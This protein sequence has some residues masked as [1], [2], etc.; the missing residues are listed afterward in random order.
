MPADTLCLEGLDPAPS[1]GLSVIRDPEL[2]HHYSS[3]V[4]M[5][6]GKPGLANVPACI[7]SVAAQAE[8]GTDNQTPLRAVYI[9]T[10]P[11][12]PVQPHIQPPAAARELSTLHLALPPLYSK[13]TLPF[14][15][16]QLT[17]GLQP[18][19]RLN[20]A[21]AAPAAK[22]K[23]AGKHV[24]PHCGRDCMKP[25]VLEKHLRCHTGER[26]YPCTTCGVSF[27][28]QSNLYKHRRTQAHARLSSE[29]EQGS[30]DSLYSSRETC[31]SSLSL[32]EHSEESCSTEKHDTLPAV[33]GSPP[34]ST[35]QA[36]SVPPE[37]SV[38]AQKELGLSGHRTETTESKV[39]K[40]EDKQKLDNTTQPLMGSRQI[41]LQRQEA[42]LFSKQWGSSVSSGKSQS[43]E[44]TDSGFSESSDHY[45]S[46]SSVLPDHSM[47]SLTESNK[48]HLG[49]TLSVHASSDHREQDSKRAVRKQEQKL[50][51]ERISKLISENTAVVEDK[52][53]EN[54]RP[55][56]T[57]LSKQGSIDLPMPYT[58]KD[59]FHFDMRINQTQNIGLTKHS[60]PE[61]HSSVPAP[62]TPS[63]QHAP[64]TRSSSLPFSFTLKQPEGSSPTSRHQPDYVTVARRGSL[65]QINP[66]DSARK[67]VN[68]HSSAHRPLVRQT[69]VDCNHATDGLFTNS[70]VEEAWTS[71]LGCNGDVGDVCG[72]PNTKKFRRKKAQ[73]FAYNKWYMYG[74]GTF[75]R[76]YDPDKR[77]ENGTVKGRKCSTNLQLVHDLQKAASADHTE[78]V[79][80]M[81]RFTKSGATADRPPASPSLVPPGDSGLPTR[82]LEPCRSPIRAPLGRNSSL[83]MLPVPAIRPL[84]SHK[85]ECCTRPE[86][87]KPTSAPEHTDS[88][89]QLCGDH[90]P[91]DRKKQRTDH[92]TIFPMDL[93]TVPNTSAPPPSLVTFSVPQRGTNVTFV[94]AL[95]NPKHTEPKA[96]LFL[97]CGVDA[98]AL[99]VSTAA[100][101][102]A[103]VT[104]NTFLPKYQ[105]K[106]PN[107]AGP[108]ASPHTVSK[109]K[110]TVHPEASAAPSDPTLPSA[111][112]CEEDC[113]P[114]LSL[115][116]AQGQLV[117]PCAVSSVSQGETSQLSAACSPAVV[118]R[119]V[120]AATITTS[121]LRSCSDGLCGSL[122]HPLKSAADSRSAH[123]YMPLA[124]A[125]VSFCSP[126]AS[127][128]M[129]GATL[130][131]VSHR[132]PLLSLNHPSTHTQVSTASAPADLRS[133]VQVGA[134]PPVT[135]CVMMPLDQPAQKVFH[136]HTADLQICLQ[137]I[138]DEQLALIAPQIERA[139]RTGLSPMCDAEAMTSEGSETK[140]QRV[141]AV[142]SGS[143]GRGRVEPQQSCSRRRCLHTLSPGRKTAAPQ[144]EPLER[145]SNEEL[146]EHSHPS[147]ASA[148]TVSA[149]PQG[150]P[151]LPHTGGHASVVTPAPSPAGSSM[152]TSA[153]LRVVKSG[154]TPP[155]GNEQ[156]RCPEEQSSPD[157]NVSRDGADSQLLSVHQ[158]S[159]KSDLPGNESQHKPEH[160]GSGEALTNKGSGECLRCTSGDESVIPDECKT[161]QTSILSPRG[162]P[163]VS[164]GQN[165]FRHENMQST[166][167]GL[168]VSSS[169][170]LETSSEHSETHLD[171]YTSQS[172]HTQ[173]RPP[174]G[175][176]VAPSI[177]V[178]TE[179]A[180]IP[181]ETSGVRCAEKKEQ[182]VQ[183]HAG[184]SNWRPGHSRVKTGTT[185]T[186][187]RTQE[188][189]GGVGGSREEQKQ[190]V[191]TSC[192]RQS[193]STCRPVV[194]Q[195]MTKLQE[196]ETRI[197]ESSEVFHSFSLTQ[198]E[199]SEIPS[200][201]LNLLLS[202]NHLLNSTPVEIDEFPPP[203]D[204]ESSASQNHDMCGSD[205]SLHV[206]AQV[207]SSQTSPS[208]TEPCSLSVSHQ[209]K[210]QTCIHVPTDE[211]HST[212]GSSRAAT[213]SYGSPTSESPQ[214]RSFSPDFRTL[215]SIQCSHRSKDNQSTE[216]KPFTFLGPDDKQDT[217]NMTPD[218]LNGQ[219]S[220]YGKPDLTDKYPSV[221]MVGS[222]HGYQPAECLTGGV[223]PVPVCQDY[224]EDTSSSDDEGK[225]IIEL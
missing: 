23:S 7:S 106:L 103:S 14:L 69:A 99:A 164:S 153:S 148:A 21:A 31:T 56:K 166:R 182:Q 158:S 137:I 113:V 198:S 192:G 114:A 143:E 9:H 178:P 221:F 40:E 189:P 212:A 76:L 22:P 52:Q 79:P 93:E 186:S 47:D 185:E 195:D 43:H 84:V 115:S 194:L 171:Q 213:S 86:T 27:K 42:T 30:L 74:G 124:P 64:F 65:G 98:T 49:E 123:F 217:F 72:E 73:K 29:S 223:R 157:E 145:K 16:L 210:N 202:N 112:A 19:P 87:V 102:A 92:K 62:R 134:T 174:E 110:D 179:G 167:A 97:P 190:E 204:C 100:A 128:V 1:A 162:E 63:M 122:M 24:C 142:D 37:G 70:S 125:A 140:A 59:S 183:E 201:H 57:I 78:T 58:Y 26:P 109:S 25:S 20:L 45:P 67:P 165:L 80:T 77:V 225:L 18:Q 13:E 15:T 132:H 50:L 2:V 68:Q 152:S 154:G 146:P 108:A 91:S 160:R 39:T 12:L 71:S 219:S 209:D 96:A 135:P 159:G 130:T 163:A 170:P 120:A 173:E 36:H 168:P 175:P 75:K 34:A 205:P 101:A 105:L 6:T 220:S 138:S 177:R 85:A 35:A 94:H 193:D 55:R 218:D 104:N 111:A 200:H 216:F 83:S 203:G 208:K 11:A 133:T 60:K 127:D 107:T 224:T 90:L 155:V 8:K 4:T 82:P 89:W 206:M 10:V 126:K 3:S 207:Q 172:P 144:D 5:E 147:E 41:L 222:L 151:Y 66:T 188:E 169:N 117:L 54:V 88:S 150:F 139:S 161:P 48:E 197:Q 81:L 28:T 95:T 211:G 191:K 17:G 184:S 180:W 121:C 131:A 46:P 156:S 196:K 32:D 116:P 33:E 176:D 44:S 53:L 119:Q 118:H 181:E 215:S 136:V 61:L 129:S 51:V 199:V 149:P 187:H 214:N 141:A 38:G